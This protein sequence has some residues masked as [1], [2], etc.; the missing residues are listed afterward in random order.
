MKLG[1]LSDFA[2]K[3]GAA[4]AADRIAGCLRQTDIEI[5]RV[6][7]DGS[8]DS[9][10]EEETLMP[11]RKYQLLELCFA[12]TVWGKYLPNR[13]AKD[14][15]KQFDK[16]LKIRKPDLINVHNLHGS[17]WPMELV[18]VALKHA[19]VCWTLHDCSTF[20]GTF[21]PSNSPR[22]LSHSK[23]NLRRF[24]GR[25]SK[26]P[27][28]NSIS[29]VAPS[30][31]MREEANASYW[32]KHGTTLIP[33]PISSDF[34]TSGCPRASRQ[35]LGLEQDKPIVLI[36]SGNLDE[37]RKG[38]PIVRQLISH[39]KFR[40]VQ[41]VMVGQTQEANGLPENVRVLG[42]VRDQFL[43]RI[44]Y[45]AA[46]F[47]LHPAPVDNLPNTVIESLSCGT[48]VLAFPVGGLPDMV[49]PNET[50]WLAGD[51]SA[52]SL[53]ERMESVLAQKSYQDLSANAQRAAATFFDERKIANLYQ[54][55]FRKIIEEGKT[56]Q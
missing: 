39:K 29:A 46:D 15:C 10:L 48:P 30:K 36:I 44:M 4:T 45:T 19:P 13:R 22:I 32:A 52:S 54:A 31:W 23:A 5:F 16:L 55:Q 41:F 6:S 43:L 8:S 35:A 47:L 33:Y 9:T 12:G 26:K 40:G 51:T 3:G 56:K 1:I 38:G 24:W 18:E 21:Y 37:E 53:I 2:K 20:L 28:G 50:G 7:S 34:K 14:L 27:M 49:I 25:L 11:S 42:F 17:D